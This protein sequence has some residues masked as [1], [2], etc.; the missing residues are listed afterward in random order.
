M[1]DHAG[2]TSARR[3]PE[4]RR[5]ARSAQDGFTIVEMSVAMMI[6]AILMIMV[7]AG[8][9]HVLNPTLQTEAIRD[10]SDQ[11][12][13]AFLDLD[14]SVRYASEL[15]E[16]AAGSSS[17]WNVEYEST[18]G[19]E[20]T[21]TELRYSYSLGELEAATWDQGSTTTPGFK[22]LASDLTGNGD[23]FTVV[24]NANYEKVQLEVTLSAIS[25]SGA[26]RETTSSS[27][28]FTALDSTSNQAASSADTDCTA[29]WT[30]S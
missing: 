25:G 1:N 23:P 2:A 19:S 27:V 10:S 16:P 14:S 7:M 30:S 15:W 29:S 5:P 17:D 4:K 6:F 12:N 21:C 18:F 8:M 11:L 26:S 9:T 20:P 13:L 24:E 28:T 22:V 3:L